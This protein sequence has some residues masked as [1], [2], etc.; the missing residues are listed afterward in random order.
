MDATA[1]AHQP[2]VNFTSLRARAKAHAAK[3]PYA[4]V[5]TIGKCLAGVKRLD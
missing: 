4:V 5:A 3:P 1:F 2:T